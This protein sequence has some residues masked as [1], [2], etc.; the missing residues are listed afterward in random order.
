[1]ARTHTYSSFIY[2]SINL[3]TIVGGK[4]QELIDCLYIA[5]ARA[6]FTNKT[7][8]IEDK[9]IAIS[10][11]GEIVGAIEGLPE[12]KVVRTTVRKYRRLLGLR[13]VITKADDTE[14]TNIGSSIIYFRSFI[15]Y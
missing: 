4:S 8:V 14:T 7:L 10:P 5:W 1:M 11:D 12:D 2:P 13:T 6:A 9:G 15:K 3:R